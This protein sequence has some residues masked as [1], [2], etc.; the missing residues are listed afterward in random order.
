MAVAV[1]TH[2]AADNE[3]PGMNVYVPVAMMMMMMI[4]NIVR[5]KMLHCVLMLCEMTVFT[6]YSK[7]LRRNFLSK[8]FVAIFF[9][10]YQNL[11][12]ISNNFLV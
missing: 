2:F 7:Y 8:N 6:L 3:W 12:L 9:F 10:F 1:D 11:E 4:L 5:C